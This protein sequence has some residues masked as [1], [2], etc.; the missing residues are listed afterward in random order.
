[1]RKTFEI[2]SN[3]IIFA[4][5]EL[6]KNKLRTFLS[7][8]GITFGIFCII[9]VMAVVKS[10]EGN[11]QKELQS[12]GSN[13]VFIDKWQWGGGSEYPWWKFVNRPTIRYGE[14]D[15]IRKK[16]TL[17]STSAFFYRNSA[18]IENNDFAIANLRFY[19]VSDD[20]NK[21]LSLEINNGRYIFC[22]CSWIYCR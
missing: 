11:I 22:R 15:Q 3:S 17:P 1:M 21:I 14:L 20:I 2:L 5:I 8:L 16:L 19:G 7:L 12:F 13:T 10:L 6:Q 9:S 4:F 18:T